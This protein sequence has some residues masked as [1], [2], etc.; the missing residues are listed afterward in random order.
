MKNTSQRAYAADAVE[1]RACVAQVVDEVPREAPAV[2]EHFHEA[3]HCR[4]LRGS[5]SPSRAFFRTCVHQVRLLASAFTSDR[6]RRVRRS[7]GGVVAPAVLAVLVLALLPE[8]RL[9]PLDQPP[10]RHVALY[11]YNRIYTV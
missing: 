5:Q 8:Q 1:L 11:L 10:E 9:Q 3:R 6:A 4:G 2:G 7:G